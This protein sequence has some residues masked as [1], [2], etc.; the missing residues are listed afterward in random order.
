MNELIIVEN[1]NVVFVNR[2]HEYKETDIDSKEGKKIIC[3]AFSICYTESSDYEGFPI[4]QFISLEYGKAK[5]NDKKIIGTVSFAKRLEDFTKT[6]DLIPKTKPEKDFS[7][8]TQVVVQFERIPGVGIATGASAS[9]FADAL[10]KRPKTIPQWITKRHERDHYTEA[11]EAAE[12]K[13]LIAEYKR[14]ND[15][16]E[17]GLDKYIKS[18]KTVFA[19]NPKPPHVHVVAHG[20]R[21]PGNKGCR[22]ITATDM[23]K[24]LNV[25]FSCVYRVDDNSV[26]GRRGNDG[27]IDQALYLSHKTPQAIE[28]G[29]FEYNECGEEDEYCSEGLDIETL[30]AERKQNQEEYGIDN[31]SLLQKWEHDLLSGKITPNDCLT[32]DCYLYGDNID[33]IKKWRNDYLSNRSHLYLPRITVFIEALNAIGGEGKSLAS[34]AL[35]RL[36]AQKLGATPEMDWDELTA[37]YIYIPGD[38]RVSFMSY[39]GQPIIIFD[40]VKSGDFLAAFGSRKQVKN[41]LDPYQESRTSYHVKNGKTALIPKYIIINSIESYD[42]FKHGICTRRSRYDEE[43]DEVVKEVQIDRRI[44]GRIQIL[45]AEKIRLLFNMGIFGDK[46]NFCFESLCVMRG[47]FKAITQKLDGEIKKEKEMEILNP[48]LGKIDEADE[49]FQIPKITDKNNLPEEFKN[50]G[51][52]IEENSI[53]SFTDVN[54]E[55]PFSNLSDTEYEQASMFT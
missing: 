16:S 11:E 26:S 29:K 42:D 48:L 46:D 20:S 18:H 49:Y 1:C 45:D 53:E 21:R 36:Y 52:P 50:Y 8:A 5:K 39:N 14:S 44:W 23:M 2:E 47:N 4:Y 19:G 33:K 22:G 54:K 27:F 30:L 12:D 17:D 34:K 37:K 7:R 15:K 38:D 24:L 3:P 31:P 25:P 40:D 51:T 28:D 9:A 10:Q 55:C 13:R 6:I 32:E 43:D 41:F 35:A